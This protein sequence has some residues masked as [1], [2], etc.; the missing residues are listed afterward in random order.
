MLRHG[1]TLLSNEGVTLQLGKLQEAA[2]RP[3][4]N[5]SKVLKATPTSSCFGH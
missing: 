3:E 2:A 1:W 4:R 5:D